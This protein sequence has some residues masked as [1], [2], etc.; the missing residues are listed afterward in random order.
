MEG[1]NGQGGKLRVAAMADLH[2]H[3]AIHGQFRAA[4]AEISERAHV[5][6]LAGDLTNLGTP[7]EAEHLA[8]DLAALR[9]PAV[10]VLGNHD[11]HSGK[12]DDVRRILDRANVTMLEEESFEIGGVGFVGVKGFGGGFG[13]HMLSAF[14]EEATKH[15]VSE[16][17]REALAL[18]NALQALRTERAVVVLHYSPILETVSGEPAEIMPFLG[19]SRLAETVDRF[20]VA[21]IFHG[22]AHHGRPRGRTLKGTPVYNCSEEVLKAQGAGRYILVEV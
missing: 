18:E 5:L 6:C 20:Q 22:H 17:V 3:K 15:F 14:G 12:P 7:E 21:A 9:I 2:M 16:A 11:H 8:A 1:G 10:A 4:F 13:S 19:C